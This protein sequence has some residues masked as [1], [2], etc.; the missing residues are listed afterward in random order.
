[1]AAVSSG[2]RVKVWCYFLGPRF[3]RGV[4]K[5]KGHGRR[6]FWLMKDQNP[7]SRGRGRRTISHLISQARSYR[8]GIGLSVSEAG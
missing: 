8:S 1:M 3:D 4:E 7:S 6:V 2:H 5:L